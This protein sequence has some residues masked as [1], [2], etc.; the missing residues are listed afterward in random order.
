MFQYILFSVTQSC[1]TLCGPMHYSPP[2][3]SVHGLFQKE[4]WSSLPLTN[5]GD[6]SN[7]GIESVSLAYP[8][9]IGRLPL[10]QL[11]KWNEVIQS[12]PTL[13]DPMDCSLPGSSVH[14]TFQARVLEWVAIVFSNFPAAMV[15][16]E[17]T[18]GEALSI[19]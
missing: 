12:C 4:H 10:A 17:S 6:L 13:S 18:T 2:V 15:T 1:L 16:P 5:P 7:Q 14:G 3:S 11:G 9:L 8:V 19:F